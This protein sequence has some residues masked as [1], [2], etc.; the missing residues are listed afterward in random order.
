MHKQQPIA[1]S[2]KVIV[3][4][5][6]LLAL[7]ILMNV[8]RSASFKA[9][10][11]SS[12]QANSCF[13]CH[14]NSGRLLSLAQPPEEEGGGCGAAPDRPYF[15]NFFVSR[16]FLSSVHGRLS[17]T[18][19]HGG[20]A[21]TGAATAA[22][23]R[24]AHQG[25]IEPTASCRACH[26]ATVASHQT[27][28]HKTL[29]GQD[30]ALLLRAGQQNFDRLHAM[31]TMDC[32]K[33]HA[34]CGDCHVSI[35]Q[36]VGGGLIQGHTF[37]KKPPMKETCAA[38]HGTRAGAEYLGTVKEG[39]PADVHF[40]KGMDCL[41]CHKEAF[42]G[43][44]IQYQSRWQV[45]G[46]PKCTDCHR[47]LPDATSRVMAH[48]IPKHQTVSCQV[49]HAVAYNNCFTCHSFVD[50]QGKYRRIP[51]QKLVLFKIG[52]NTVPGYPYTYVPVRHNPIARNTFDYFGQNLLPFF[53]DYPNWKTAAPHNI[54]RVTPQNRTCG[55]CHGN[56]SLFLT[57]EDLDAAD[58]RA[59][60]QVVVDRIP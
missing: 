47:A 19:C 12:S 50:A 5:L 18:S 51:Q 44:G 8:E 30:Q 46:L 60:E 57:R 22:D 52:R 10:G 54:Q 16:T 41:A 37:F 27:S 29:A 15:L 1:R 24:A 36:G 25:M 48:L 58:P 11:S 38:C 56:R 21:A 32:N 9:E 2:M 43:D 42:H 39:L 35:P 23:M 7:F 28:L 34:G 49:C 31:R 4:S 45:Q 53:D 6:C 59:N 26:A 3:T 17:C 14:S 13:D 40:T 20:N 33:C 55:A